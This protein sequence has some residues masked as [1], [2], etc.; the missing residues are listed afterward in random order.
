MHIERHTN[1]RTRGQAQTRML[2][3][4]GLPPLHPRAGAG[5]Q[6]LAIHHGPCLAL[7]LRWGHLAMS[8][9][10][11]IFDCHNW[12]DAPGKN[13]LQCTGRAPSPQPHA[14]SAEDEKPCRVA[15]FIT[16]CTRLIQHLR[17]SHLLYPQPRMFL[18]IYC[19][20]F[21]RY[22]FEAC[23][24]TLTQISSTQSTAQALHLGVCAS[25]STSKLEAL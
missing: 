3:R 22:L 15:T 11:R 24:C 5:R 18:P 10:R 23:V 19:S 21:N 12:E 4:K 16:T 20:L 14:H 17:P 6:P 13:H 1:Q 9:E 7:V 25:I 2:D 8:G